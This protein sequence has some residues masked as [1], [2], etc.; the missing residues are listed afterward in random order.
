MAVIRF[1]PADALQTTVVENGVYPSI[2]S[3]IEG[4]KAST[5]GKSN[6]YW[7]DIQITDGKY[8]GKEKTVCFN[9][10][11]RSASL[12]GDMPIFPDSQFLVL[13]SAISG[14]VIEAVDYQIDTDTLV[15]KPFD[16]Q[17]TVET[18]EG[19]LVNNIVNFF[20]AGYGS[21]VPAF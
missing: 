10:E 9:T 11:M 3:K 1:T 15:N 8:K 20:K 17:W 7:L 19:R 12:M 13:D 2:V 4:P 6:N 16:C 14:R 5:S 21:T 18:V